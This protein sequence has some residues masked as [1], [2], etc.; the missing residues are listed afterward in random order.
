MSYLAAA[1]VFQ[2]HS[3]RADKANISKFLKGM[4]HAS[5][6]QQSY[7]FLSRSRGIR[8]KVGEWWAE[9]ER[10]KTLGLI[11]IRRLPEQIHTKVLV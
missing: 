2:H 4:L 8:W 9:E 7:S 6:A 1:D 3:T 5:S 10:Q 11:Q